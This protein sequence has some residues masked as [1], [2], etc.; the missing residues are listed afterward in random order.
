MKQSLSIK[1][2]ISIIIC[3][4]LGF[5]SGYVGGSAISDWYMNL[6]K[7]FFQPPPWVFGPAWTLLYTLIGIALALVWHSPDSLNKSKAIKLF[8]F[9]FILN[10]VWSPIFFAMK[11][12]GISLGVI[13]LLWILIILTIQAFKKVNQRSSWLLLPYLLW[14]TFATLLNASI[15][16]L[17]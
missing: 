1:I 13:V 14:V 8:I 3:L 17:N 2:A 9:Q 4:G 6:N 16:Y 15:V 12:P 7:P 10:L 11:K 5:L